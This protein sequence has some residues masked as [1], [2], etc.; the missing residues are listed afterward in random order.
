MP[1]QP[2]QSG[3]PGG[4]PKVE[5]IVK[6][7]ARNHTEKAINKLVTLLESTDE[8]IQIAA[9]QAILDR[10][11]GKPA[12]AIVGGDDE[13]NPISLIQK[14]ERSIVRSNNPDSNG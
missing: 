12:Q 11:Y 4:R 6:R 3:N 7:I 1:F 2:G 5:N 14:I 9:A 13:D 8:R 10:G